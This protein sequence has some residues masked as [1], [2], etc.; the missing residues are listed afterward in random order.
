MA[1]N[2]FDKKALISNGLH[3]CIWIGHAIFQR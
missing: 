1:K 3:K 2:A